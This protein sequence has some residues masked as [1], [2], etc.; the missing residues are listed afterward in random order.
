MPKLNQKSK[1]LEMAAGIAVI[2]GDQRVRISALYSMG[3]STKFPKTAPVKDPT[4]TQNGRTKPITRC[5]RSVAIPNRAAGRMVLISAV[6]SIHGIGRICT[7]SVRKMLDRVGTTTY[8]S[9]QTNPIQVP[10]LNTRH[11]QP[12]CLAEVSARAVAP[13]ACTG[14]SGKGSCSISLVIRNIT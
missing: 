13:R 7:V 5:P 4:T 6:K 2:P 11:F 1:R 8:R 10:V 9:P 3:L 12:S 14:A